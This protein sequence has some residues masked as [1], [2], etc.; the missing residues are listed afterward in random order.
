MRQTVTDRRY[1]G[2]ALCRASFAAFLNIWSEN[3][4]ARRL[5]GLNGCIMM[6]P[7]WDENVVS[8]PLSGF[9]VHTLISWQKPSCTSFAAS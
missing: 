1:P 9:V 8:I 6:L 3:V 7:T 4:P 2:G 5:L